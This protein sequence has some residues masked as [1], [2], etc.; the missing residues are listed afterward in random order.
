[1]IVIPGGGTLKRE[2]PAMLTALTGS[3][4]RFYKQRVVPQLPSEYQATMSP[5]KA[6]YVECA[7]QT[8]VRKKTAVLIQTICGDSWRRVPLHLY[9]HLEAM[10]KTQNLSYQPDT[11]PSEHTF[12]SHHLH[13]PRK[14]GLWAQSIGDGDEPD[15]NY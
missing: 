4:S 1:M 6:E 5:T 14:Q 12:L 3:N 7:I 9:H 13:L 11:A 15:L 8:K 10:L 2:Q